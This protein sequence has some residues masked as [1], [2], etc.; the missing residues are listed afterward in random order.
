M[1]WQEIFGKLLQHTIT[2]NYILI[3]FI[4]ESSLNNQQHT[5][6]IWKCKQTALL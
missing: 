6:L 1:Q 2:N 5:V 3:V 4:L